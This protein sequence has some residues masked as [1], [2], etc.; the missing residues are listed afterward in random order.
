[1]SEENNAKEL[2]VLRMKQAVA[3][4]LMQMMQH[5]NT[6]GA[7]IDAK[8][9]QPVGTTNAFIST[10]M[11]GSEV[12]GGNDLRRVA[13]ITYALEFSFNIQATPINFVPTEPVPVADEAE[14]AEG[15]DGN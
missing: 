13:E 12:K 6:T 3:V 14:A 5:R 4:L 10:L 1:M 8:L 15:D 9:E 11:D 2:S 7:K